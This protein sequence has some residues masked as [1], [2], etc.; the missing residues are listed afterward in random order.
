M[1]CRLFA[2][3]N[4]APAPWDVVFGCAGNK[5]RGQDTDRKDGKSQAAS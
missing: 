2:C 5:A 3:S 1:D 4:A